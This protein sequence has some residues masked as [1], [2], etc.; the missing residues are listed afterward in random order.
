MISK[1]SGSLSSKVLA[2]LREETLSL[3]GKLVLARCVLAR[4]PNHV[5]SRLHVH[6]LRAIGFRGIDPSVSMWSLP[7][8]TGRGDIYSRLEVG[9][10]SRFN[11]GC[12][13][14]LGE[15]ITVG[16]HVGFGH[17]VMILTETHAVGSPS[18]R[19]GTSSTKPVT[20]GDGCWIG[21]RATILPGVTIGKGAVVAAGAMVT[22]DVRPNTLVGGVPARELKQLR[23]DGDVGSGGLGVRIRSEQEEEELVARE[24]EESPASGLRWKGS[25]AGPS[26]FPRQVVNISG[27]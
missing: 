25:S 7:T 2:V 6:M 15:R 1:G 5:G 8:F 20:I 26:V 17:Q 10:G 9:Y 23:A 19:A 14:N 24:L 21:A 18:Y 3:Q 13:L 12:F 16:R 4:L 11:V 27:R 22:K